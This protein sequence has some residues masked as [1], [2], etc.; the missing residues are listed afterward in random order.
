MISKVTPES[1][2]ELTN[3]IGEGPISGKIAKEVFEECF[4]SGKSPKAIV[5]EK[6]MTQISDTS[7]IDELVE[8]VIEE[9]PDPVETYKSGKTG[10]LG[11]LVGQVM[12]QSQGRANPGMVQEALKKRLDG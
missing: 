12:K 1:L 10:V 6:G 3:L 4:E 7:A 8:K 2:V 5:K 9:N 11:F